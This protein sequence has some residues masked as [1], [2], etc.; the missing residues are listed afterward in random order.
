MTEYTAEIIQRHY[1]PDVLVPCPIII[2]FRSRWSRTQSDI[3]GFELMWQTWHGIRKCHIMLQN[4]SFERTWYATDTFQT[5]HETVD[6]FLEDDGLLIGFV[7][8][9]HQL[10]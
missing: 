8:A 5:K 9:T 3:L 4:L 1:V 7:D 2:T 6:V 10:G